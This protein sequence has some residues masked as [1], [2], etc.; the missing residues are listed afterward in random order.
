VFEKHGVKTAIAG[1]LPTAPADSLR[2]GAAVAARNGLSLPAARKAIT[3]I[4]AEL[5]G[6]EEQ[7]GK[8]E[9]GLRADLVVFSGDPLDLQS[10]VLAV[11]VSGVR[12]PVDVLASQK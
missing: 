4:P 12:V 1:G 2:I 8:I 5:L 9:K 7:T 10:R 6:I 11:Y 3:N